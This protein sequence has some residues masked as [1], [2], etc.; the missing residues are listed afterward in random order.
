MRDAPPFF[1]V[2]FPVKNDKYLC[3]ITL[4][5]KKMIELKD[6]MTVV[7]LH[8]NH[9]L[10]TNQLIYLLRSLDNIIGV[11]F[12]PV[13]IGDKVP[14][15]LTVDNIVTTQEHP[16][17]AIS[18]AIKNNPD[19]FNQDL[20]IMS[21][22]MLIINKCMISTILLPKYNEFEQGKSSHTPF[23]ARTEMFTGIAPENIKSCPVLETMTQ[24]MLSIPDAM[25]TPVDFRVPPFLGNFVSASPDMERVKERAGNRFFFH[26]SDDSFPALEPFLAKRFPTLGEYETDAKE[27]DDKKPAKQDQGGD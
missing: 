19:L 3:C 1:Y 18:E 12:K 26:I 16:A 17:L 25:L 23:Y 5:H 9:H 14:E 15:N 22:D 8:K 13:V 6:Q 24:K 2:L 27:M 21:D 7:I 20:I 11:N 10:R 4:K